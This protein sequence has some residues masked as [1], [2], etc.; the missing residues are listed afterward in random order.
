M[1]TG[2]MLIT[3]AALTLLSLV[4]LRINNN[5]LS[6]GT[7]MNENKLGVMAISLG[8]S[9]LEEAKSKAFDENTFGSFV[10]AKNQLS[11][12]GPDDGENYPNFNDFDD[13]HNFSHKFAY[14]P[15]DTSDSTF[16]VNSVVHYIDPANPEVP[17]GSKE[18]HKRMI[19]YITSES[20][21]DTIELSTIYSYFYYR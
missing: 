20:M 19:I 7:V 18:W 11:T 13:Y 21:V 1:N 5:F 9:L 2:Q 10:T 15:A 12:P 17:S 8:T 16:Q 14:N 3:I 6:T 4:I